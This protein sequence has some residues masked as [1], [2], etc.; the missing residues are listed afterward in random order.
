MGDK[1][2]GKD[3]THGIGK[4][5]QGYRYAVKAGRSDYT[6]GLIGHTASCNDGGCQDGKSSAQA[7]ETSGNDHGQDGI[8]LITHAGIFA[9]KFIEACRPQFITKRGLIQGDVQDYRNK[10]RYNNC[11]AH[12]GVLNAKGRNLCGTRQ[13]CR[14]GLGGNIHRGV[15]LHQHIHE[16]H[17]DIVKHDG[18]NYFIYVKQGF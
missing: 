10:N 15:P 13:I 18:G 8:L 2:G 14:S 6:D 16:I 3:D 1:D 9:G 4:S 7:G 12:I 17:A 5:K 11:D